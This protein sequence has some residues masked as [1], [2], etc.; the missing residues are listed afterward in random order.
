M[1]RAPIFK[2]VSKR[3]AS[4]PFTGN[5]LAGVWST[6]LS[7]RIT[8]PFRILQIKMV[9]SSEANN[10]VQHWWHTSPSLIT[11]VQGQLTADNVFGRESPTAFFVGKSIIRI[12]N[13][14]LEYPEGNLFIV[15]QTFNGLAIPYRLNCEIVIEEM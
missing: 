6:L 1:F 7:T 15:L 8:Y 3:V 2:P 10:L 12:V 5:V 13:C 4:I 11:P 9:F 14:S